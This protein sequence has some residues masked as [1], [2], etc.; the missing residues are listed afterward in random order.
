MLRSWQI[1]YIDNKYMASIFDMLYQT[2]SLESADRQVLD[3]IDAMRDQLRHAVQRVPVAGADAAAAVRPPAPPCRP[4]PRTAHRPDGTAPSAAASWALPPARRWPRPAASMPGL[5]ELVTSAWATH[6]VELLPDLV[7][8]RFRSCGDGEHEREWR[9]LTLLQTYSPGT[10]PAPVEADLSATPPT[11]VMSRLAGSP[12]RGTRV[13]PDQLA[14][15][16]RTLTAVHEAVPRKVAAQLPPRLWN[17]HQ[18]VRG[19]HVRHEQLAQRAPGPVV[20]RAATAGMNWLRRSGLET[21]GEPDTPPVFGQADGNLANFLWDGTRVR[22]V[23]F[24]DSGRSDRA[25]ELADIAEHVSLWVDS[26]FDIAR[27]LG[28]FD[29]DA[30]EARRLRECRRLFSLLWLLVLALEDPSSPRNPA[31]TA[32]RQAERLLALLG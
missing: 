32:E 6:T 31:G 21:A 10:A 4:F 3:Q 12:L 26:E 11:V 18:A 2:P 27:F 5:G 17:Q 19:I 7:V 9:A 1:Q 13:G 24:E 15:M 8:K 14:A 30:A 23:D 16:A 29:L 25:Y 20:S 28:L 22:V